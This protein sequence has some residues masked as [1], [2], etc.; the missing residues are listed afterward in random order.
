MKMVLIFSVLLIAGLLL[1]QWLPLWLASAA[2]AGHLVIHLLTM[3]ALAYIMI[4]VGTEFHVEKTNLR[5]YGWD[6]VIAVTAAAGPWL[7]VAMYFIFVLVPSELW[8][9]GRLWQESLLVSR[10]A[11]PTSAGVLFSM[12]AAAGMGHTWVF[13]KARVLAI[14]D[15][16]DTVVLMIPLKMMMVGVAWQ[17]MVILAIFAT[18]FWTA[19]RWMRRIRLPT[20]W[21]WVLTYSAMIALASY[22]VSF[23]SKQID[24]D[25][26]IDIEVLLPAFLLGVALSPPRAED[27]GPERHHRQQQVS[28]LISAAFMLLVGLN[29]PPMLM[30]WQQAGAEN[31]AREQSLLSQLTMPPWPVL[32]LHVVIVTALCNL[33]KMFPAFCYRK[34]AHWRLRTG[35]A[36]GMW[37]RGEVGAGV[38]VV[39]LGYGIAGPAMTISVLSLALN[40]VL[41]GAFIVLVKWLI[42]AHA[43]NDNA[44]P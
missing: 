42:A 32:A 14:F 8:C 22:G 29:M 44:P 3:T 18:M 41:T 21:P 13:R 33:G 9:R 4:H 23:A 24:Q 30:A 11:A 10:F 27:R 7:L 15:D 16:L 1:A 6:Y 38:L 39:S 2:D 34:E 5:Q 40:L 28:T 20:A 36:V 19:W 31:A 26:P 43:E 17:L 35:V 12:L 25:V 37:P